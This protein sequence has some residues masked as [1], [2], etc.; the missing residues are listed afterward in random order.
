[1]LLTRREDFD[2]IAA[3]SKVAATGFDFLAHVLHVGKAD[4]KVAALQRG[5]AFHH[6]HA[7]SEFIR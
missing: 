6:H 1:M 2:G 5:T 3:H 4:E 7:V